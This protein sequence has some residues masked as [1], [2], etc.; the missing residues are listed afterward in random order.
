M[1]TKSLEDNN[2]H[3]N[4]DSLLRPL[5]QEQDEG[6]DPLE[7]SSSLNTSTS[8]GKKGDDGKGGEKQ[9]CRCGNA[10]SAPGKLTC[11][12]QRCPCYVN[13]F[14]CLS[15][16]CKGLFYFGKKLRFQEKNHKGYKKK[17]LA[18]NLCFYQ[19]NLKF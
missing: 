5:L 13:K 6:V 16:K 12:G 1:L 19:F 2:H 9:G 7:A 8:K 10:T 17:E 3:I 14:A 11:C 18:K 15:C 4:G